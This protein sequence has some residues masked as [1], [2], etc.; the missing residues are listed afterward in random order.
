MPWLPFSLTALS[1]LYCQVPIRVVYSPW[2]ELKPKKIEGA[3]S[4]RNIPASVESPVSMN[5]ADR[6]FA[7]VHSSPIIARAKMF[8]LSNGVSNGMFLAPHHAEHSPKKHSS[9]RLRMDLRCSDR[10]LSR[11]YM[12]TLHKLISIIQHPSVSTAPLSVQ[13]H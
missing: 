4:N 5:S 10:R 6:S 1:I 9:L 13:L 11:T 8:P 3:A 2:Y 12:L 7:A